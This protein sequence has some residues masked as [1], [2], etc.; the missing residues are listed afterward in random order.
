M[1]PKSQRLNLSQDFKWV[2][3]GQKVETRYFKIRIQ[4]GQNLFPKVGIA[5]SSKVFKKAHERSQVKRLTSDLIKEIYHNLPKAMNLVIMP[6]SEVV[7]TPAE[8]LLEDLKNVKILN[9]TN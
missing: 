8:K 1:L 3:S 5:L 7:A 6:K 2:S 9:I 4:Y